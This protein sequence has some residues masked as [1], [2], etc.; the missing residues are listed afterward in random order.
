MLGRLSPEVL[1][2]PPTVQGADPMEMTKK[3]L[4]EKIRDFVQI[5]QLEREL[6]FKA[7]DI[8][9]IDFDDEKLRE[10]LELQDNLIADIERLR[11]EGML[12]LIEELA[13]F[14]AEK[15]AEQE[16]GGGDPAPPAAE[17]GQ[18][19]GGDAG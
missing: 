17:P 4:K 8:E 3:E 16:A 18:S 2:G 19:E 1:A 5:M 12:P 10:K 15:K 14:V 11:M 7:L 9:M 6:Q 13:A